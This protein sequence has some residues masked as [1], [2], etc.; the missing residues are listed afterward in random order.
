MQFGTWPPL[1]A[2]FQPFH[3]EFPFLSL[4]MFCCTVLLDFYL[5]HCCCC[6][7][8]YPLSIWSLLLGWSFFL[9][10]LQCCFFCPKLHRLYLFLANLRLDIFLNFSFRILFIIIHLLLN[11]IQKIQN[12]NSI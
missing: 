3:L 10:A 4:C 9:C 5:D 11:L 1:L 2:N 7:C 8:Q 6:C 12:Q